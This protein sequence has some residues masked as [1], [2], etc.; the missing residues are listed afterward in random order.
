MSRDGRIGV[1]HPIRLKT[2]TSRLST[3]A[4]SESSCI[5]IPGTG[6]RSTTSAVETRS[7]PQRS[8]IWADCVSTRV[9][10]AS[11]CVSRASSFSDGHSKVNH[12]HLAATRAEMVGVGPRRHDHEHRPVTPGTSILAGKCAIRNLTKIQGFDISPIELR[13][14]ARLEVGQFL[15]T[16]VGHLRSR[17]R[18]IVHG[19]TH[20]IPPVNN[21]ATDVRLIRASSRVRCCRKRVR[22]FRYIRVARPFRCG[23]CFVCMAP[24][25]AR[26]LDATPREVLPPGTFRCMR[27]VADRSR[28]VRSSRVIES[29][30]NY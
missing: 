6:T 14:I 22:R 2:T 23:G 20:A 30:Y 29:T 28:S 24:E 16:Q 27:P 3:I 4:T 19:V 8:R 26:V 12:P 11:S 7:T 10:T 25:P 15:R 18:G 9:S 1:P 13:P 5:A 21:T 17:V